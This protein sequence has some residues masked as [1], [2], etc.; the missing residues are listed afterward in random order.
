VAQRED[1]RVPVGDGS[2]SL[3]AWL[4]RPDAAAGGGAAPC[5]VMAHGFSALRSMHLDKPAERF[6]DA[7]YAVLVFDYRGFGDSDGEPQVVDVKLQ[8]EDFAAAVAFARGLDGVVDPERIALWGTS[9]G[10]GN[11]VV[12][13]ARDERLAAA[14]AQAPFVDGLAQARAAPPRVG[15]RMTADGVRDAL[16]ARRGKPP[17]TIPVVAPPGGYAVLSNEH[18]WRALDWMLPEGGPWRN[19]VAARIAL[20][21][22]R[23]RPVRTAR[24]VGCPLLVQAVGNETVVAGD[25]GRMASAAPRGELK[26][27]PDLD[28][29][30]VYTGEGFERVVADQLEFLRRHVPPAG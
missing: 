8:A 7:G 18:A 5:V 30:D 17:R 6:A 3:G 23:H 27:Y 22:G 15:L 12:V 1:I 16:G 29:F 13:A 25:A 11:V 19:E 28:H 24:R 4:Y 14:I 26:T 21:L 9:F 20:Q 10:G 2:S